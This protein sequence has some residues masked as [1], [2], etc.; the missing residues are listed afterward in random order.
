MKRII[1]LLAVFV[2]MTAVW[3]QES[4]VSVVDFTKGAGTWQRRV[5]KNG[6]KEFDMSALSVRPEDPENVSEC[7]AALNLPLK[8]PGD[9][10]FVSPLPGPLGAWRMATHLE[11]SFQFPEN[12]PEGT[13]AAIFT[14][15][16]DHLWRQVRRS[17]SSLVKT[18]SISRFR[19]PISGEDAVKE[20]ECFG[21]RRPWNALTVKNL[22][23]YGVRFELDT[24]VKADFDGN[25]FLTDV[26]LLFLDAPKTLAVR[27]FEYAPLAPNVG[28]R[29]EF[30]FRLNVWPTEPYNPAKT[31]IEAVITRPDAKEDGTGV[32]RIN[33]F[34]YEDFLYNREEWDKTKC[35]MPYGE[36]C[37]KIRYCPRVAGQHKIAIHITIDDKKAEIPEMTFNATPAF[38]DYHGFVHLDPNNNQYFTYDDGTLYWGLGMNVR[39]PFDNRYYEVAPYSPWQDQGLSVY[40][41]L[42]KT[43]REH[44]INTAEVWMCSW[45]L[46][47]EWINDAPGFH[48][49]GQFNQYRAWMLD[50]ILRLAEE[51]GIKLI[52]VINNH[53][54]FGMSYDTEWKR[55]PFNKELGGF[56]ERCEEYFSNAEAKQLFKNLADYMVARWSASPNILFWKLFTE[57]DLTGPDIS[58]YQRTG[59]IAAWHSEMGGYL[60]GIDIYKHPITTHWM[61]SYH[62][63]DAAISAVPELDLLTTDAYYSG[64]GTAQLINLLR[65]SRDFGKAKQKPLVIT[66]FGGSSYADNMT[67]L[68][69]QV[70]V[71]LW[72]GFFSEMSILPMYWWFALIEDKGLYNYYDAIRL[73]GE[74]ED[75]RGMTSTAF[76]VP[77]TSLQASELRKNDRLMYWIFDKA[78][79]FS[80]VENLTIAEQN[81]KKMVV[82]AP[83]PG[84]YTMEFWSPSNGKLLETKDLTVAKEAK[85]IELALP[86]FTRSIA[87]KIIKK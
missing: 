41:K 64:G 81:G 19:V 6:G 10:E 42:F 4:G 34:Y 75:R 79:F 9:G 57:V 39:S 69:K 48:G 20:W 60:K 40:E 53:G 58:Y 87:V 56:L 61:L 76:D 72:T 23:E 84:E 11:F 30:S 24:G 47:L 46:A 86:S 77:N 14:K 83:E 49:V 21:H 66:E 55:N 28:R 44:G 8:F 1:Y 13:M 33:G 59:D 45:W 38:D 32:E 5:W 82:M 35:L 68:V 63:I 78:F 43:Y 80:D 25:I 22:L 29:I 7:P 71:G 27:D 15:D 65:G 17:V 31:K 62:R 70:E 67:N 73:F 26:R 51:N 85:V 52:L 54:K 74:K 16:N 37:F 18:G 3:A 12:L 50:Y 36:P 2:A